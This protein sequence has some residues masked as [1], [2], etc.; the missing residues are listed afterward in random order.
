M[1]RQGHGHGSPSFWLQVLGASRDG[2]SWARTGAVRLR[3]A[4]CATTEFGLI[5]CSVFVACK[6]TPKPNTETLET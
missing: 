4:G 5:G 3:A 2:P 6:P 1:A